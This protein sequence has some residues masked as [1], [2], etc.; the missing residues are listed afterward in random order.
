MTFC[1][2]NCKGTRIL[3]EERENYDLLTL[4]FIL[5]QILNNCS[6]NKRVKYYCLK[7]GLSWWSIWRKDE[8]R[9]G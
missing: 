5:W 7:I 8:A 1:L 2:Y 4:P 3:H 9:R 6:S